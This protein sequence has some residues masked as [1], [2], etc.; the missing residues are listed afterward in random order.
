MRNLAVKIADALQAIEQERGSFKVKCLVAQDPDDIQWDL[1]LWADWFESDESKRL[2]YLIK[3]IMKPLDDDS[4]A[5][6]NAIITFGPED[7]NEML[8][9]LRSIQNNYTKGIFQTVWD[10]NI[11]QVRTT[12]PQ[13]RLVIPLNFQVEMEKQSALA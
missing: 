6:F 2:D 8:W 4:L 11:M 12:I 3:K 5:Q 1:V 10:G 9:A 13:A 7:N